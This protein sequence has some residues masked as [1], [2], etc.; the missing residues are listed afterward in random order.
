MPWFLVAAMILAWALGVKALLDSLSTLLFL[1]DANL[2]DVEAL[3]STIKDAKEPIGPLFELAAVAYTRSIGEA[4]AIAFPLGAARLVLS[5]L[6]VVACG[7]VMSG[8]PGSH[9]LALQ[10]L[11]AN[12]ALA[13]LTF[14]LM[15]HARYAWADTVVHTRAMMPELAEPAPPELTMWWARMQDRRFWLWLPRI[16]LVLF[17]VGALLLA[18][19][20]LT[21]PRTKAFFDAAEAASAEQDEP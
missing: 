5:M 8:R 19:M 3:A 4:S 6:L 17:D 11:L 21:S 9:R 2:P 14:W 20:T 12:A 1:R 15:R 13:T 7:M 16:W 18:A 10:A